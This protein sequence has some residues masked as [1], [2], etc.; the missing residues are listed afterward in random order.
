MVAWDHSVSGAA[1]VERGKDIVDDVIILE[2]KDE[3]NVYGK[4]VFDRED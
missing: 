3:G 4:P 1:E 2:W